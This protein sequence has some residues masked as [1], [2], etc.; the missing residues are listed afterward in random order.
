MGMTLS[1]TYVNFSQQ[2]KGKKGK[3]ELQVIDLTALSSP[4]KRYVNA[5]TAIHNDETI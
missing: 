2:G 1:L 5:N 3:V 4:E